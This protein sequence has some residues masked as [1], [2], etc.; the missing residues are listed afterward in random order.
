MKEFNLHAVTIG[1]IGEVVFSDWIKRK[2]EFNDYKLYKKIAYFTWK[3][4]SFQSFFERF[5][6]ERV[7][8]DDLRSLSQMA[9]TDEEIALQGLSQMAFTDEEIAQQE[10][11]R[12]IEEKEREREEKEK[13]EEER[14]RQGLLK[15]REKYRKFTDFYKEFEEVEHYLSKID[16]LFYLV[17][18]DN[19]LYKPPDDAFYKPMRRSRYR[20]SVDWSIEESLFRD[21]KKKRIHKKEEIKDRVSGLFDEIRPLVIEVKTSLKGKIK[22]QPL[23]ENQKRVMRLC[24]ELGMGYMLGYVILYPD[25]HVGLKRYIKYHGFTWNPKFLKEEH[26]WLRWD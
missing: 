22:N 6:K 23:K 1:K 25:L 7:F 14:T 5:L 18:F 16:Q 13:R 10:S 17:Q 4:G 19:V 8:S 2:P 21:Y 24:K 12:F 11:E 15:E 3:G 26:P 9:L 20:G